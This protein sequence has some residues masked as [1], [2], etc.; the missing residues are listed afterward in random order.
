MHLEA[1]KRDDE[2]SQKK[3]SGKDWKERKEIQETHP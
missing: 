1:G 3:K 2:R